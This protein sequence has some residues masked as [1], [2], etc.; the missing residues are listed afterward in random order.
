MN[1]LK[2]IPGKMNYVQNLFLA[3]QEYMQAD[4][5]LEDVIAFLDAEPPE[6]R[7]IAYESASMEIALKD[8]TEE[9]ELKNWKKFY[10]NSLNAHTFHMQIGLGWAFA[11]LD[12]SPAP[13]LKLLHPT[14]NMM[15]FDGIG[16]YYALYRGRKT[17]KNQLIPDEIKTSNLNGFDQGVGRRLWY[18]SKGD[19]EQLTELTQ[20]FDLIR[21]ADLWRGVGIACGYVGGSDKLKLEHL[22]KTANK[23]EEPLCTGVS[24]AAISR[25]NANSIN[26]D[27]ELACK[28]ICG[29]SLFSVVND[30]AATEYLIVKNINVL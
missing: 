10:H 25:N 18:I 28:I 17:V 13:H 24:L 16:Y 12:V 15:V 21:H 22:L 23:F 4:R 5:K 9:N 1:S 11:K 3:V 7:S 27:I 30:H 19:V 26:K 6:F 20:Q 8:L 14:M 2:S 29:K